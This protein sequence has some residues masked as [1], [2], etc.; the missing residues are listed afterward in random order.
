METTNQ[1]QKFEDRT[2]YSVMGKVN[3]NDEKETLLEFEIFN[4]QPTEEMPYI[5]EDYPYGY[6]RTQMR[7]YVESVKNKGDR[8]VRQTLNPKTNKW[9]A[10]KK[11]T[12]DE[13][14]L[15]GISKQTGYV[16]EVFGFSHWSDK[17]KHETKKKFLDENPQIKLNEHQL[18]EIKKL[19]VIYHIRDHMS[20][21]E[22]KAVEYRHKITGEIATEIPLFEM[23][24][25][26]EV[27]KE[28]REQREKENDKNLAIL[29]YHYSKKEGLIE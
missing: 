6:L 11:S 8:I 17:E 21:P 20:T 14:S 18:N 28:E 5:I 10:P 16:N 9:N 1:N 22:F 24:D 13:V 3:Y 26:E 2:P 12:Y 29:N 15:L 27:G 7:V 4:T 19:N 25:Y 23:N